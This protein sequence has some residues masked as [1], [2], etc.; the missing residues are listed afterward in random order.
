MHETYCLVILTDK[1]GESNLQ[2]NGTLILTYKITEVW[3]PETTWPLSHPS[4]AYPGLSSQSVV[5]AA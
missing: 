2:L 3:L 5:G 4:V 1:N